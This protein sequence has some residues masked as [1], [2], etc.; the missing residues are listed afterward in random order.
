[1]T[2]QRTCCCWQVLLAGHDNDCFALLL[3]EAQQPGDQDV[4]EQEREV[5]QDSRQ[6]WSNMHSITCSALSRAGLCALPCWQHR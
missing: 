1:M 4:D 6:T 2:C 5:Q 3:R